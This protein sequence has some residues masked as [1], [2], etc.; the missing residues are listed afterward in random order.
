MRWIQRGLTIGTAVVGGVT[1]LAL[2]ARELRIAQ[3][4]AANAIRDP[5]GLEWS[6]FIDVGGTRQWLLIRG[7]HRSSEIVLFL[8]GG[9]GFPIT[10][11]AGS[12]YQGALEERFLVVHWEQRGAGKSYR[13]G[14]AEPLGLE[15]YLADAL[16]VTD[17]LRATFGREKIFLVGHSHGAFL[18]A[19]LAARAPERYHAFVGVGQLVETIRQEQRF[20]LRRNR[21]PTRIAPVLSLG[22][23]LPRPVRHVV[24]DPLPRRL[25][26]HVEHRDEQEVEHGG[27][28]H[29]AE[30]RRP[31]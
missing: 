24:R 19:H 4:R 1:A 11:L 3:L 21:A 13:A 28:E 18:G 15:T 16:A 12:R 27:E 29:P 6:G 26:Q 20:S 30:H 5:D 7:Q 25:H 23:R 14:L 31:E 8:H 10:D 17:H 9:P 22:P 2:G